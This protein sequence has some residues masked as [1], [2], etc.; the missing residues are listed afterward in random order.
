MKKRVVKKKAGRGSP[1]ALRALVRARKPESAL[2]LADEDATDR[3]AGEPDV[4]EEGMIRPL[5][6]GV[7]E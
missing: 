2:T 3:F 6:F 1:E 4:D 5:V 7:E